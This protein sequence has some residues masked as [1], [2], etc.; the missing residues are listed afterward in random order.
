MDYTT[1]E[2]L[3]YG[4][5]S[6]VEISINGQV[7]KYVTCQNYV[8]SKD[9]GSLWDFGHYYDICGS[10]TKE[11]ALKAATLDLYDAV[12]KSELNAIMERLTRMQ[13]IASELIGSIVEHYVKED[14]VTLVNKLALTEDE[15]GL[16]GVKEIAYPRKFKVI[17]VD[18]V[19][20]QKATI[21][22]VVPE[23]EDVSSWSLD[24]Y[25]ECIDQLDPEDEGEWDIDCYDLYEEDLTEEE[26]INLY[27]D[28][29]VWNYNDIDKF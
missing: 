5:R 8:R 3:K 17:S 24:E 28:S 1:R 21:K 9:I 2:I 16:L 14:V 20:E 11:E 10:M 13:T 23:N 6:V 18:M 25:I 19:R 22:V 27:D 15:A 4:D 7:T 29:R 26:F 12:N